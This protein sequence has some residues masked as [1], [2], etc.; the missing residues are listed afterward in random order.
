MDAADGKKDVRIE[1]LLIKGNYSAGSIPL[2]TV[3]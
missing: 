3:D 1:K 2:Y